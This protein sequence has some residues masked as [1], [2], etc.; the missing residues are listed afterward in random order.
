MLLKKLTELGHNVVAEA[1]NGEEAVAMYSEYNPD[2]VTMDITMPEMN[3]IDALSEIMKMDSKA[4][5]I[6]ITSHGEE[7]KVIEAIKLGA[8]GYILKPLTTEALED[9]INK[10]LS[11]K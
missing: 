1:G 6:M 8:K 7:K 5:V 3:G 2:L 4:T 9:G 10:I 11:T